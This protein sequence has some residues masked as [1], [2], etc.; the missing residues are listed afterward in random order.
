VLDKLFAALDGLENG[1][2][3]P[4][5]GTAMASV[6]G[7]IIRVYETTELAARLQTLEDAQ[8]DGALAL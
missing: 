4:R 7:A 8:H 2:V 6:S 5:V 3:D 1:S